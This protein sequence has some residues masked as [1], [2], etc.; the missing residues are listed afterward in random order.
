M[1]LCKICKRRNIC[2]EICPELKKEISGRGISPRRKDKTYVVNFSLL[3][4]SQ[5]LN[6]FQLEVR[7]KLVEDTIHKQI[8]GI[9]LRNLVQKHLTRRERQAIQFLLKGYCQRE[10]AG[11]M[12]I[13]QARVN[14]LVKQAIG[15][16]KNFF[17]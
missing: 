4:S 13:S 16:L 11:K 7:H 17:T 2:R 8:A 1:A 14:V 3:E 12:E 15:K 6:L 9:D 10:I 5:P